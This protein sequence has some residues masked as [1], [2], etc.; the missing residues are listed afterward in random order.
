M[1]NIRNK[2]MAN[3]FWVLSNEDSRA[4]FF[5]ENYVKNN[6]GVWEYSSSAGW[7]WSPAIF[8]IKQDKKTKKIVSEKKVEKK[9]EKTKKRHSRL[10][11]KE[12]DD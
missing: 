5:R 1:G 3:R 4:A 6:G 12:K 11:K 9:V 8:E 2:K 10:F 7:T